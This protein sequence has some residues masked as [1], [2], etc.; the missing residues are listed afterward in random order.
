MTLKKI[1]NARDVK[2]QGRK[3]ML[4]ER[5]LR[6][7]DDSPVKTY[8]QEH[9]H[10]LDLENITSRFPELS[11]VPKRAMMFFDI[12]NLGLSPNAPIFAIGITHLT[13]GITTSCLFAR[14]YSEE[15]VILQYFLDMLKDHHAFFTYNGPSFDIPRIDVRARHGNCLVY[16]NGS[17]LKEMLNSSHIDL[18]QEIKKSKP[19]LPDYKLSTI[20][21]LLFK[22]AR[23]KDISSKDVP[24]T[25]REY[26]EGT[27]G[28]EKM[29]RVISHNMRDTLTLA[30]ILAFICKTKRR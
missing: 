13:E 6:D 26:I 1:L 25:Y 4:V 18:R 27:D 7:M 23:E 19:G 16:P 10:V 15:K 20:E 8:L 11:K 3:F 14:D 12:E 28:E 17:S 22:M 30:A 29:A 21:K 2:Y 5:P 24:R 9:R